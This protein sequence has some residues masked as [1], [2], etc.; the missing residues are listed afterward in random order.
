MRR[1]IAL[2][3]VLTT[4]TACTDPYG[5][6]DPGMTA[7]AVGAGALAVGALGYAAGQNS[8]PSYHHAPRYHH[9]PAYGYHMAPQPYDRWGRAVPYR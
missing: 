2:I 4:L 5:R 7:L 6:I 9:A 3:A 1:I 8:A